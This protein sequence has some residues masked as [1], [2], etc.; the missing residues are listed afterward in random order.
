MRAIGPGAKGV[1]ALPRGFVICLPSRCANAL[2]VRSIR[3]SVGQRKRASRVTR[4]IRRFPA[5]QVQIGNL[6]RGM[7]L[8]AV[9][10]GN[11]REGK[12]K[13]VCH[14]SH[15][16]CNELQLAEIIDWRLASVGEDVSSV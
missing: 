12:S 16:C 7:L 4:Q 3:A 10:N 8:S 13:S 2:D 5:M 1:T 14:H 11:L 15:A 9:Q 6:P